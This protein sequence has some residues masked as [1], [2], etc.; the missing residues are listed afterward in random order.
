VN[1]LP[2]VFGTVAPYIEDYGYLAVALAVLIENFGIPMPGEA[3]LVVASLFTVS[4]VLDLRIVIAVAFVAAVVGDNMGY[5]FG[6]YGGRPLVLRIGRRFGVTNKLLDKVEA[7]FDRHGTKVV[8]AARFLPIMR[9]LNGISA[10]LSHMAWRRFLLA[11][12]IGAAVWV[13][14]WTFIG[15][16]AGAHIDTI[17]TVLEKGFRWLVVAL[18]L[19]ILGWVGW[20]RLVRGRFPELEEMEQEIEEA[21]HEAWHEHEHE[22]E[23]DA[24]PTTPADE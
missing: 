10:G 18:V 5:A 3:T 13:G 16:R 4:G 9:H 7:F 23:H 8:V 14:V 11:N 24:D 22:H 20:R 2:G 17:N 21:R 1:D 12:M 19:L 6:R 15:V